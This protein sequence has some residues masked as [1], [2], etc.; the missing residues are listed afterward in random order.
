MKKLVSVVVFM[1]SF[2]A[3]TVLLCGLIG[4]VFTTLP[5]APNE[6]DSPT[7][8]PDGQQIAYTCYVD[9][10]KEGVTL[11]DQML[12]GYYKVYSAYSP[13]A[14]DICIV[15]LETQLYQRLT[16]YPTYESDPLF[17]PDGQKIL[18]KRVVSDHGFFG[19]LP[20]YLY[21]INVDGQNERLLIQTPAINLR[22]KSIENEGL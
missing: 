20:H 17:S 3:F 18:F 10:P 4:L 22:R 8:S 13:N 6:S 16:D 5:P 2:V 1:L 11:L 12:N 15:D 7:W 9:G 19:Y 21:L 14:A